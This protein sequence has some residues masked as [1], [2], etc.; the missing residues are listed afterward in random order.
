MPDRDKA[1][2]PFVRIIDV[3]TTGLDPDDSSICEIAKIDWQGGVLRAPAADLIDPESPIPAQAKAIHHITEEQLIGAP[4]LRDVIAR[5]G[6]VEIAA[7]HNA[8]FD[9]GFLEESF[10]KH[11]VC[12]YKASLRVWPDLPSHSNQFLRYHLGLPDPSETDPEAILPHRALHDAI[13]TGHLFSALT[14]HLT[15]REMVAI[16]R[17]PALM[18]VLTFGKHR[19]IKFAEAPR[20]YLRWLINNH[21]DESVKFSA[22]RALAEKDTS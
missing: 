7:A 19:G 5:Y 18:T 1:D 20:D 6:P 16:S 12:T 15:V 8:D 2:V 17:E 14:S 11:W 9:R 22:K 21:D 10:A 4:H 13:V 3:E